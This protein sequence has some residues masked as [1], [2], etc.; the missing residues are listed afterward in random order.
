MALKPTL[1]FEVLDTYDS[2]VLAIADY[3]D[4]KHMKSESSF[5]DITLPASKAVITHN[6]QKEKVNRFNSSNLAYG[7]TNCEDGLIALP[8][9]IYKI[10]I[11]SC[12]GA[13]FSREK[14]YLRTVKLRLRINKILVS[15]NLECGID[16]AC[17]S[18]VMKTE[19]LL[20]GAEA[21][22]IYGNINAAKR[23]YDK[24]VEI[25]EDLEHCDCTKECG[26]GYNTSSY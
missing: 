24:V 20:K 6:F 7:C 8:D 26:D 4:W 13:T 11:Y 5:I 22:L 16:S 3:S 14:H 21:D 12:D 23:K 17:I 9:G 2:R 1:N 25:V 18:D 19:L 15:L 10:K